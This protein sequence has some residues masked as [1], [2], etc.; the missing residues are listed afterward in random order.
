MTVNGSLLGR[1]T[2]AFMA[3]GAEWAVENSSGKGVFLLEDGLSYSQE[4]ISY[5]ENGS[6]WPV[7]I[8]K[9]VVSTGL[10]YRQYLRFDDL[11]GICYTLGG[12]E[13]Q[14]PVEINA[15]KGDYRHVILP[16][17]DNFGDFATVAMKKGNTVQSFPSVKFAGFTISGQT[18][19]G[20]MEVKFH[21]FANNL[22]PNS[23]I[24]TPASFDSLQYLQGNGG[25]AF[26]RNLKIWLKDRDDTAITEAD[27]L[28]NSL[29]SFE[30]SFQ[31]QLASDYT[32]TS[33]IE[34]EE[35]VEDGI[36]ET[37]MTL[38]FR[39]YDSKSLDLFQAWQ[40]NARLKL[41]VELIG[42]AATTASGDVSPAAFTLELPN[43]AVE[44]IEP[45]VYSGPGR[46]GTNV[47]LSAMAAPQGITVPGMDFNQPFKLTAVNAQ[48]VK[49]IL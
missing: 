36:A 20:R 33:G 17:S 39:N 22:I 18:N 34:I 45:G 46:I 43:V 35:P 42:A 14:A 4:S 7:D 13:Y 21:A 12:T 15:G 30:F 28:S 19:P 1:E 44:S 47:N 49:A 29:T 27:L 37:T 24:I 5:E 6:V 31:R 23:T 10:D 26:F 16:A 2:L 9:G 11:R 3:P 48:A 41:K 8:D 38:N 40:Q 32:N 25:L